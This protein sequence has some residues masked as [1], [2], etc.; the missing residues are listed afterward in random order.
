MLRERLRESLDLD[1]DL[2][3]R[4]WGMPRLALRRRSFIFSQNCRDQP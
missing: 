4:S 2:E 1:L 3:S